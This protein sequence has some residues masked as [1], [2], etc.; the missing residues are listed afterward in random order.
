MSS[1][2]LNQLIIPAG[3]RQPTEQT[4]PTSKP[5]R[6]FV[7]VVVNLVW[8]FFKLKMFCKQEHENQE[9]GY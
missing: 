6:N 5:I 2:F 1:R 3:S 4:I 9:P 7:N 8:A